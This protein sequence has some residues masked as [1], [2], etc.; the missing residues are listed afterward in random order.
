MKDRGSGLGNE[1]LPTAGA[2]QYHSRK[3]SCGSGRPTNLQQEFSF[4][5]ERCG[6]LIENK[7][8]EIEARW[9]SGNVTENK[10]SYA[11][12]AAILLKILV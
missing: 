11:L 5:T 1:A 7:G 2:C 10:G 3:L 12:K 6:D 9:K 8:P 4:L